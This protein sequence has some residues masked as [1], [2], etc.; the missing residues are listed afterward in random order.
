MTITLA[1]AMELARAG[2]L[3]A[4]IEYC[5]TKMQGMAWSFS[6]SSGI[7]ADDLLQEVATRLFLKSEKVLYAPNPNAY[8]RVLA[9]N[10]M[11]DHYRKV[12]RRRRII[13]HVASLDERWME[14]AL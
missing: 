14:A 9:R 10:C 3:D 8:A 4:W 13:G 5:T 6:Q 7:A 11:I 2:N 12:A 1:E